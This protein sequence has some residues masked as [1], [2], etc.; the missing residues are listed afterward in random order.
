VLEKRPGAGSQPAG[1]LDGGM[2]P[3]PSGRPRLGVHVPVPGADNALGLVAALARR[4][5]GLDFMEMNK[6]PRQSFKL[7]ETNSYPE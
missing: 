1:E 6:N 4:G 3:R 5:G 2:H 7:S